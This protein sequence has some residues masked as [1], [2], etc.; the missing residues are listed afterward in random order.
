M[1]RCSRVSESGQA[2]T[3]LSPHPTAG[4]GKMGGAVWFRAR[5]SACTTH[6]TNKNHGS[7][8]RTYC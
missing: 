4:V 8:V 6:R 2:R 3:L 1:R 7:K 5:T